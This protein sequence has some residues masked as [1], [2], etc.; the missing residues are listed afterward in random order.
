MSESHLQV[1]SHDVRAKQRS[2]STKAAWWY[3]EPTGIHVIAELRGDNGMFLG[4]TQVQI[5]WRSIRA[6]LARLDKSD[7]K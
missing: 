3:E 4:T 1:Q 5:P 7:S 6:A 2:P